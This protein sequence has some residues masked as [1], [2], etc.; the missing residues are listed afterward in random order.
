MY[1]RI[2]LLLLVA[3]FS[4]STATGDPAV[5]RT[6]LLPISANAG[7]RG[8]APEVHVL[9]N[10][11]EHVR[12]AFD[13]AALAVETIEIDGESYSVLAIEG[14]GHIG[15]AGEPM[16]PTFT[17]LIQIPD[18]TG[19]TLEIERIET[20]E[21]SGF[22]PLPMQST[23]AAGFIIDPAAYTRAGYA[24]SAP[25]QIG[26]PAIARDLRVVPITFQPVRYDPAR[27]TIE[28]AARIEIT[29]RFEGEDRRNAKTKHR[30]IIPESF[31]RLYSSIVLN[32]T[33]PRAGQ[34]VGRGAYVIIGRNDI[35]LSAVAPLIEWR[36]RQGYEVHAVTTQVTGSWSS[37]IQTWLREAY[38]TW[39]NPPEYITLVGDA[40]GDYRIRTWYEEWSGRQGEGDFPY[41]QLDGND[42]LPDAHIG[43][44][45]VQELD[46]LE[47]YM[48]KIVPYESTP[49]MGETDW[50]R[51][52][53]LVGDPSTSGYTCVQIMQWL[54]TRLLDWGYTEIDTIFAEPFV[55]Q[56]NNSLNDGCGIFAYRGFYGMSGF[57]VGDI[58]SLQNGR[59]LTFAVNLT[60]STGSFAGG[61]SPSEA[62]MRAGLPPD[63]VTGGVGCL[64]TATGGTHTRYNNCITYGVW[65]GVFW[66]GLNHFGS[67]LTRGKYE[68][69][70][71]Y[72]AG[73]YEN[74]QIFSHWNNLMGDSAG[75]IWTA[76]PQEMS[77]VHP[78]TLALGA[79]AVTL[80]VA[81]SG[82]PCEQAYVCLWKGDEVHVGG[83]TDA[84]GMIDLPVSPT[85]T[86]EMLITVTKHDHHPYLGSLDVSAP[87]LF[88]G[89]RDHQIDDSVGGNGDGIVNPDESILLP[90]QVE[91]FGSQLAPS[92]EA[93]LTSADAFVSVVSGLT[94][95][96]DIPAG[97]TAWGAAGF[98]IEIAPNVPDGHMA[99]LTL[100]LTS[101]SDTWRAIIALPI[102]SAVFAFDEVTLYDFG[103]HIDP[104]ETG[105][106]SVRL[107][108]HGTASGAA[109]TGT[110]LSGNQWVTVTDAQGA[111]GTIGAGSFGEN[112]GDRFALSVDGA[113]FEGFVVPMSLSLAY[114]DGARDTV[115]FALTIGAASADDPIGPDTYGYFAFDD[116]DT[117]YD[118]APTY[119]WVEIAANH[120]GPGASLDLDDDES[121]TLDLPFP[122][123]Y[124]GEAFTRV[125]I[126]SNGWIAMGPTH[127][128]NYRNW[129]IPGVG[130][131]EYL[132]TPMWDNLY[133]VGADDN[134]YHWF[135]AEN[136][137]YV[138]QWSRLYNW[139]G[140]TEQNFQVMLYDA[141]HYPT[142]TTDGVIVFQ[143]D[144]FNNS[145]YLQNY[146]TTGI[147]NGDNT[148]GVLYQ[149]FDMYPAGA[150]P[151]TS[152]RAIKFMVVRDQVVGTLR[153][154]IT[155]STGGGAPIPDASVTIVETDQVFTG[156]AQ[157]EY[158]G[159]VIPGTYTVV[160]D[161]PSFAPATI[162]GVEIVGG[163]VTTLDFQLIDTACPEFIE[164]TEYG[165]TIDTGGPYEIFT[166]VMDYSLIDEVTLYY[167]LDGGEW[168]G[169]ACS[170]L[171]N[172][173]YR[174]DIPGQPYTTQ[175]RYYVSARDERGNTATDP[176]E[177]PSD[178]YSFWVMPP[179]FIDDIELGSGDWDHYIVTPTFAD[180]WHRSSQRNHT[181][182]GTWSWKFGDEGGGG[183]ADYADGALETPPIILTGDATL[184]FWHWMEAE[185]SSSYPD[186]AY[187][188]GLIE[189]SLNGGE[190][191]QVTPLGGY[192][193]LSRPGSNPGPF[194]EATPIY[195]GS[196]DWIIEYL[197]LIGLAGEVRVRFRFGSDGAT[198]L[199]GW[200]ID[201]LVV[202][203][204]D[205]GMA[206]A[207]ELELLPAHV[208]LYQNVPNPMSAHT[209]IAFDLPEPAHVELR[210][211]DASGRLLR[212]LLE[213]PVS[214]GRHSIDWDG[215]D[216]EGAPVGSGVYFYDLAG[217][218]TRHARRMLV[219]Q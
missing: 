30:Q 39:P 88:V 96:G 167:A 188:G 48:N 46:Q 200:Y 68:L 28:V 184:T 164:T 112:D 144:E 142:Q 115:D 131:P 37:Q 106:I 36:T 158:I 41:V 117:A 126:C 147:Q 76:V 204:H 173:L 129:T 26:E 208:A 216:R 94:H 8:A 185:T 195:S 67:C 211:F 89:Y 32:Y 2:T 187:D 213:G 215:R 124:Y 198:G 175:V 171:G 105:E 45:S 11:G 113:C 153:G 166:Q 33:G 202:I 169:L 93:L 29:V 165:H 133:P 102:V 205:P 100:D 63:I 40:D 90:V 4:F 17:R 145:D 162:P 58:L 56:M 10:D 78:A 121:V 127:L 75:E 13:L 107:Y 130:A 19:I 23:E 51:S 38:E 196:F 35:A 161:H 137:R 72:A 138:I 44:I 7:Q 86:G 103:S 151:I 123:T 218:H 74:V 141:N 178:F 201:D 61:T 203:N 80:E 43:R 34:T 25:V 62:W 146:S 120:G 149:Y 27:A 42:V 139:E 192:P 182:G 54:K 52:A 122:F 183:Y 104:G 108:N 135:D 157:G 77:V 217:P 111:F 5:V 134:V 209:R 18:E 180:E 136:H 92:V 186:Q 197:E 143:F 69:F 172:D 119:A 31:E 128:T 99:H 97:G 24:E 170:D 20:G 47:L 116:T 114:S 12:L 110:L 66:E 95:F 177:A 193:Y 140:H 190:W 154:T 214:A 210:V 168:L 9:A 59:K 6:G 181:A 98:A 207:H 148:T 3:L 85:S 64:G 156:N 163:E 174:A 219:V 189:I 132:I 60:C 118:Q 155:N 1:R 179:A 15:G 91:N 70:L 16:L 87:E 101:G 84:A 159:Q 81:A 71:N 55:M 212:T 206:G 194:P 82:T 160:A 22:R 79:N 50:Y 21:F 14:G 83:Y 57:E 176:P 191:S 49:Y 65:R 53:C 73:D 109:V 199:E 125:T 152:G 150:A